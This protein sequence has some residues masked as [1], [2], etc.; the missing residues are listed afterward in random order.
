MLTSHGAGAVSVF[1]CVEIHGFRETFAALSLI[2]SMISYA[3]VI[4]GSVVGRNT[5]TALGR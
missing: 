4:V 3:L 5:R 1:T 2:D